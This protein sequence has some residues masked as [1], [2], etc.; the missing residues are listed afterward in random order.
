MAGG[1]RTRQK[2]KIEMIKSS[3]R[4]RWVRR[5]TKKD[6]KYSKYPTGHDVDAKEDRGGRK[7][8]C[9]KEVR[10]SRVPFADP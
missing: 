9:S 8:I 6:L 4:E 1:V 3:S 10:V 5:E 7:V 2:K